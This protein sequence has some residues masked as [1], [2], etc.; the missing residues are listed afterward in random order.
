MAYF[1]FSLDSYYVSRLRPVKATLYFKVSNPANYVIR[2]VSTSGIL[3]SDY[4]PISSNTEIIFYEAP[5]TTSYV[6]FE[7]K[8][9]SRGQLFY[10]PKKRVW[11]SEVLSSYLDE[12]NKNII[13]QSTEAPL[14]LVSDINDNVQRLSNF[15]GVVNLFPVIILGFA[16]FC[17]AFR[18]G[19]NPR[20]RRKNAKMLQ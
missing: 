8:D 9:L 18:A 19:Y 3:D 12:I 11:S 7:I 15:G 6:W 20:E 1:N 13:N 16:F 5:E 2:P 4:Q 10:T 17:I 14:T